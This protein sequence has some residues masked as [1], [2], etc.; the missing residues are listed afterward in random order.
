MIVMPTRDGDG[1]TAGG[2]G[3]PSRLTSRDRV[4]AKLVPSEGSLRLA[5]VNHLLRRP[6]ARGAAGGHQVALVCM[7]AVC[8]CGGRDG[9]ILPHLRLA[10]VAQRRRRRGRARRRRGRRH[11][12]ALQP[13]SVA[14]VE[15]LLLLRGGTRRVDTGLG[16]PREGSSS[17]GPVHAHAG[18]GRLQRR[19]TIHAG[20]PRLGRARGA[21]RRMARPV[22]AA[23]RGQGR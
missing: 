3:E 19:V 14:E 15:R 5:V 4:V 18:R 13:K 12:A 16:A 21:S 11:R 10:R 8:A 22:L 17:Q 20:R 6:L 7:H 1:A 9:A 2:V 23:R